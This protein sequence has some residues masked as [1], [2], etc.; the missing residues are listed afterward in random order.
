MSKKDLVLLLNDILESCQKIKKY[1]KEYSFADFL[2]DDRTIDAV[3]R[4]FT[5]IGEATSNIDSD[6][7]ILNPHIEW[8]EIKDFRN[9]MVHD[10]DGIDYEIV[11]EI[12][13]N[14][15]GALEF[16]IQGLLK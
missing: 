9:K 3:I 13:T 15:I 12:I 6:F 16:Q 8:R 1:T 7:K 11:W 2:G 5:I 14:F 4:N 10:Y